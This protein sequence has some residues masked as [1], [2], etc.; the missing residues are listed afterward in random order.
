MSL[1]DLAL[2]RA[3]VRTTLLGITVANGY[4]VELKTSDGDLSE[5]QIKTP[6]SLLPRAW[7]YVADGAGPTL[8]PQTAGRGVASLPLIVDVVFNA[9]LPKKGGTG[10]HGH[11][12]CDGWMVAVGKCL[13]AAQAAPGYS[14]PWRATVSGQA[15]YNYSSGALTRVRIPVQLEC[16]YSTRS[17]A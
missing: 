4:A 3:W 8:T 12:E 17:E 13:R 11:D 9:T 16:W 10:K 15:E 5:N 6:P 2:G 1:T 7:V 14:S